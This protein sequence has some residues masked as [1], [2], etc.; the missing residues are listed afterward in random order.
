[1]TSPSKGVGAKKECVFGAAGR[2]RFFDFDR[3][4]AGSGPNVSTRNLLMCGREDDS[5]LRAGESAEGDDD[6]MS[7][8][9]PRT[10]S[11]KKDRVHT[12]G[13]DGLEGAHA[14]LCDGRVA[15]LQS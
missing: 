11:I 12:T 5:D 2:L 10:G 9:R 14:S 15:I 7:Q 6:G 3:V 13:E 1:M 4:S 8:G